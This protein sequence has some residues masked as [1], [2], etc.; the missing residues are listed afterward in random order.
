VAIEIPDSV[1]PSEFS[2][3]FVQGMA[4]R[5]AT[6]YSNKGAVADA[7]PVKFDAVG[8]LRLQLEKYAETGNTEHLINAANYAMIEFMHPR[9]PRA[10][11]KAEDSAAS[12]GRV[13]VSGDTSFAA[14]THERELVRVGFTYGRDGD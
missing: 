10:Y 6:S 8:C 4:N 14:N 9:H 2:A 12:I 5:M 11:F 1:P 7:F 3:A 13:T